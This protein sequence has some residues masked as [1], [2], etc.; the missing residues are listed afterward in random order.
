MT[1]AILRRPFHLRKE[2]YKHAK[3]ASLI[4]DTLNLIKFKSWLDRQ[5][6]VYFNPSVEV[7]ATQE[8]SNAGQIPN[9]LHIN[10]FLQKYF[11]IPTRGAKNKMVAKVMKSMIHKEVSNV[12]RVIKF[13]VL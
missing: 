9:N 5:L 10:N 2:I 12:G 1:K 11:T 7:A 6:K 3:D 8:I 4:D 13:T